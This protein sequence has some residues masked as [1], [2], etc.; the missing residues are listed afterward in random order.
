MQ[1]NQ[2][3][4]T[5]NQIPIPTVYILNVNTGKVELM[6]N[7]TYDPL[8]GMPFAP[9]GYTAC[10][11]QPATTVPTN[12][13]NMNNSQVSRSTSG[14][15]TVVPSENVTKRK[16][17]H[18]SKQ[19]C[20]TQTYE[21]IKSYFNPLGIYAEGEE[22]VLRGDDVCRVHVKNYNGL[23]KIL[24]VL[25]QVYSHKDI[26]LKR[27]ATPISMKNKF[28]KKG[29]I[30]YMQVSDVSQVPI[31]QWIFSNY[32]D[33]YKKCDV[34]LKKDTNK[35]TV[36]TAINSISDDKVEVDDNTITLSGL[37]G[38]FPRSMVKKS[39]VGA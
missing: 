17:P 23:K 14:E 21:E 22:D 38:L 7:V 12:N 4:L 32:S 25:K 30:V 13:P 1:F 27:L 34:A 36:N 31:V 26:T 10:L 6:E 16:F 11:Y 2:Q 8:T 28:Q 39:S 20:I 19:N 29:F 5:M 3:Q 37:E 24:D 35:G 33:L 9:L 18:R 15:P